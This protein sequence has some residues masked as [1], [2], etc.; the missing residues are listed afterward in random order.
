MALR[1]QVSCSWGPNIVNQN[2][3]F[4]A[5]SITFDASLLNMSY[6]IGYTPPPSTLA[7]PSHFVPSLTSTVWAF[8][9]LAGNITFTITNNDANFGA[10]L[11]CHVVVLVT[12]PFWS[13]QAHA[14]FTRHVAAVDGQACMLR[15]Q[16]RCLS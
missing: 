8:T 7:N 6:T 12:V 11:C 4:M 15:C 2:L 16:N 5:V 3:N 14:R 9:A 10:P 13:R 1:A